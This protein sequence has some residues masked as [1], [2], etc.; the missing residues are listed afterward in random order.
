MPTKFKVVL[1]AGK[2]MAGFFGVHES[3][4]AR[5]ISWTWQTV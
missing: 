1:S 3:C 4:F 2:I 5:W